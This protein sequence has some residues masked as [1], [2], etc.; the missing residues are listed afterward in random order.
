LV[1]LRK[2]CRVKEEVEACGVVEAYPLFAIDSFFSARLRE[3][4]AAIIDDTGLIGWCGMSRRENDINE[5]PSYFK[6]WGKVE[7]DGVQWPSYP[8]IV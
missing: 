1:A 7:K 5:I 4:Y 3:R 2:N 8:I 6:H